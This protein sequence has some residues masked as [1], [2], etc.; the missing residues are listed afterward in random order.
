MHAFSRN[1]RH[2]YCDYVNDREQSHTEQPG[3]LGPDHTETHHVASTMPGKAG[4]RQNSVVRLWS[5]AAGTT[6]QSNGING[7]KEFNSGALH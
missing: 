7:K 5:G 3:L 1:R 6:R 4:Q 2:Y